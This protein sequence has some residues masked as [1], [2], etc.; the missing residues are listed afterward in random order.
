MLSVTA[1]QEEPQA[2]WQNVGHGNTTAGCHAV[3][4]QSAAATVVSM[5]WVELVVRTLAPRY[6]LA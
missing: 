5:F 1:Q 2:P 3:P 4:M 6:C